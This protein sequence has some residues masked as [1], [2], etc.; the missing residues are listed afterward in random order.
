MGNTTQAMSATERL[1]RA[2]LELHRLANEARNDKQLSA[3]VEGVDQAASAFAIDVSD[4]VAS[5]RES[6]SSASD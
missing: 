2:A 5:L 3:T 6:I 1:V 4:H